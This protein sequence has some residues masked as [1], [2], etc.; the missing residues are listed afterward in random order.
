MG[1]FP[2]TVIGGYEQRCELFSQSFL[3]GTIPSPFLD[4]CPSPP[5][6]LRFLQL[7]P[8]LLL[9]L[10]NPVQPYFLGSTI[11]TV[12]PSV[13]RH[14][15]AY[16]SLLFQSALCFSRLLLSHQHL[17]FLFSSE[18]VVRVSTDPCW[19]EPVRWWFMCSSPAGSSTRLTLSFSGFLTN[20]EFK[21]GISW[22]QNNI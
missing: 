2:V 3:K 4:L 17:I 8:S 13:W 22:N 19:A 6:T 21:Q 5:L 7:L 9:I 1:S 16:P 11:F 10:S 18:N 15:I 12:I 14:P 20:W